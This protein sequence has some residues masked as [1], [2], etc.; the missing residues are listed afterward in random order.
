[1]SSRK[2]FGSSQ[3]RKADDEA[4]GMEP[5]KSRSKI[6]SP[7]P[8]TSTD[9]MLSPTAECDEFSE[10]D[11]SDVEYEEEESEPELD[12][13]MADD[14]YLRENCLAETIKQNYGDRWT[15]SPPRVIPG[16]FEYRP[17][18]APRATYNTAKEAF[19]AIISAGIVNK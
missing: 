11:S 3:K 13:E 16:A 17:V 10:S 9:P 5:T 15:K 4:T 14:R 8:S 12:Y 7:Q 19:D 1:M 18:N 2:Q 6:G